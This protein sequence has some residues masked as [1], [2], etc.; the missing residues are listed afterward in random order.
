MDNTDPIF[1]QFDKAL[2]KTTPTTSAPQVPTW[3]SQILAAQHAQT[4]EKQTKPNVSSSTSLFGNSFLGKIGNGISS[5]EQ[6]VGNDLT[7]GAR[8]SIAAKSE[9]D[10]NNNQFQTEKSLQ[11]QIKAEKAKGNDT[12]H[13]ENALS[14]VRQHS[15]SKGT[16]AVAQD[17]PESQKTTEQGL[18]DVLSLGVDALAPGGL[19]A[20]AYGAAKGAATG[21]SNNEGVGGTLTDTVVGGVTGKIL[22]VG[23]S[24]AAP[25]I[26]DALSKYGKPLFDK[27]SQFIPDGAQAAMKDLA[28]KATDKL[29]LGSG[30][31][32]SDLL[33]KVN[34]VAQKPADAVSAI[35]N[36]A[37]TAVVG[38]PE[39]Q[40]TAKTA[41]ELQ[42]IKDTISPKPTAK[43]A[44][45]ATDQGRLIKGKDP[46]LFKSG[47]PDQI[48]TSPQ[49]L[50]ST[51]TVH[52]LIPDAATMDEPTL[53]AA[54]DEKIAD[55]AQKL[56][57]QMEATA[58]KP[59]TVQK[60]TD[61]WTNLKKTQMQTADA[62]DEPNVLK[63]QK[64]FETILKKSS[65]GNMN[66]LWDSAKS[67]DA[68]VPDNVKSANSMS[69][70]SLQNKK[71]IWM[72]NRSILRNAINDSEN[73]LGK[74]SQ[75]A[76]SDMKDMYEA[77]TG[78]MSKA[79]VETAAA[80]SKIS[81]AYNS[82]KGKIVRNV[83]KAG[84]G[85]EAGKKLLGL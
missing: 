54:L 51:M 12:T 9:N 3:G 56:K 6:A 7:A 50:K 72:Q 66:D 59:E 20:T 73:G 25:A 60:I 62:T 47:T 79:K 24:K 80:P 2:G 15:F 43:E 29:S 65:S 41:D 30:N 1:S 82:P 18:G 23:F 17:V 19:S 37:K 35:A 53:H 58:I 14:S 33:D 34:T 85:I 70:E 81:Q 31:A 42:K 49:Q 40:A 76:F 68:S 27:I 77:Q 21:L 11:D 28:Q 46:T 5:A 71:T 78:I 38:T 67:Y 75:Q 63:S 36:K 61:D 4:P 48:A 69:S 45:L 52:R 32:G 22:D 8:A 13:L 55:T 44:K 10:L 57:P 39:A 16:D 64:Q 84:I 26:S 83:I 74:T